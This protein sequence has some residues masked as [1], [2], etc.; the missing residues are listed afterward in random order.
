MPQATAGDAFAGWLQALPGFGNGALIQAM[1]SG[2][3]R[4]FLVW[5]AAPMTPA[6]IKRS[7]I[8]KLAEDRQRILTVTETLE[9]E[10][11]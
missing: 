6:I 8:A 5:R 3:D 7:A 11:Y 4:R 2:V 9:P 10:R 1:Y